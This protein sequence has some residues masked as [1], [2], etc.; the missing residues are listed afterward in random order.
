MPILRPT[1]DDNGQL[2]CIAPVAALDV[3]LSRFTAAIVPLTWVLSNG[4]EDTEDR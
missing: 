2:N 4:L 3:T 1:I